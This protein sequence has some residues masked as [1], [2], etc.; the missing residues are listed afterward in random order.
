MSVSKLVGDVEFIGANPVE[1]TG[2][3]V[4]PRHLVTAQHVI[5][6][7]FGRRNEGTFQVT[8]EN[9]AY[10]YAEHYYWYP[11]PEFSDGNSTIANQN[12]QYDFAYVLLDRDVGNGYFG[13]ARPES[14]NVSHLNFA[15]YPTRQYDK[16]R[17]KAHNAT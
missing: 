8:F 5:L 10:A 14:F 2:W 4:E 11:H 12:S 13:F 7:E 17:Q 1:G 6:D 16:N 15:G 3:L 9:G